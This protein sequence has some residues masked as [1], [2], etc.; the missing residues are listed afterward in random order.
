[1]KWNKSMGEKTPVRTWRVFA[2]DEA[3]RFFGQLLEAM[4]EKLVVKL[5]FKLNDH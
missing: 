4:L 3:A 1:M 2:Q 5:I